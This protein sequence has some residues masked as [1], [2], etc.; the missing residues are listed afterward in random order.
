MENIPLTFESEEHYFGSFVYPLL[1]ETRSELASSLEIMY[2][3]PFADILSLK[4]STSGEKMLYDVRVSC[5]RYGS[6]ER[7]IDDYHAIAVAGDLLLLVDGKPE[8]LSD[9]KRVGRKWALS[10]V[11]SNED[12]STEFRIKASQPIEFQD[13]MFVV[14]VK[15]LTNPKRIWDSLHMHRN[16][17]IIKEILYTES[18]VRRW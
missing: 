2:K 6:S 9:L 10:L 8:S 12:T 13:G 7:G 3:A 5:W 16:L 18:T 4:E 11:K 14:F 15:N 17:H 1:E